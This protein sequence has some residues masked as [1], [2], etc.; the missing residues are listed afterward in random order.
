MTL[1]CYYT[2]KRINSMVR[3]DVDENVA[4]S[5]PLTDF[6]LKDTTSLNHPVFVISA[7]NMPETNYCILTGQGYTANRPPKQ[8]Y[9][10]DDIVQVR[11]TVWELH[12]NIDALATWRDSILSQSA[13]VV[14]SASSYKPYLNDDLMQSSGD[15]PQRGIVSFINSD[16]AG[17]G[18]EGGTYILAVAATGDSSNGV[19]AIGGM[20][21]YACQQDTLAHIMGY[22]FQAPI[23]TQVKDAFGDFSGAFG[24]LW[25]IPLKWSVVAGPTVSKIFVAGQQITNLSNCAR[26]NRP[27]YTKSESYPVALTHYGDFRDNAPYRSYFAKLPF[28]G[29]VDIDNAIMYSRNRAGNGS[30]SIRV[31]Q[32]LD[33][34]SGVYVCYL[35]VDGYF[36][37]KFTAQTRVELPLASFNTNVAGFIGG[38]ANKVG[39]VISRDGSNKASREAIAWK[40]ST[41]VG[42]ALRAAFRG[43]AGGAVGDTLSNIDNHI[44]GTYNING[45]YGG[46]TLVAA[47][48]ELRI[49]ERYQTTAVEPSSVAALAGRPFA[50]VTSLGSLSGY[51]L[52]SGFHVRGYMTS[53]EKEQIE[54]LFNSTGVFITE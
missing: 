49:M 48:P 50:G 16:L 26:I 37:G 25:W 34:L 2:N 9:W 23:A 15:Y 13:F 35:S 11:K 30:V 5:T 14:R 4:V 21:Y 27:Y 39:D 29:V 28:V 38:V 17:I 44:G 31:A 10:I 12:C 54:T 42:R 33:Y 24:G 32:Y 1:T 46:T 20:S 6:F 3:P 52:T 22:L 8:Y 40:E 19:N 43:A 7:S 51:C 18:L 36:L 45:G 47:D 41:N 53:E